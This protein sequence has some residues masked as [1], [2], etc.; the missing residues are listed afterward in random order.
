MKLVVESTAESPEIGFR[1][2]DVDDFT[3]VFIKVAGE[4]DEAETPAVASEVG[5]VFGG[6]AID[7]DFVGVAD[8]CFVFGE[9]D[10]AL[11][12]DEFVEA[13]FADLGRD[14]LH[15]GGGGSG[16]GGVPEHVGV[17][18]LEPLHASQGA[19][20][21]FFGF[22]GEADDDIGGEADVR[23]FFAELVDDF[24]E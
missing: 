12:G 23:H 10:F 14:L 2:G 5:G 6:D 24:R 21:F 19:F 7:K 4:L 16:S 3:S 1:G 11:E 22:A 15:F 17:I 9:S 13:I 18:E 20:K 8:A